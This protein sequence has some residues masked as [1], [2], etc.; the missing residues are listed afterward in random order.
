MCDYWTS[1]HSSRSFFV[2]SG[3]LTHTRQ[4]PYHGSGQAH[5]NL[6]SYKYSWVHKLRCIYL[7]LCFSVRRGVTIPPSLRNVRGLAVP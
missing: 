2:S 5:G 6:S 3:P 1:K 4:D 7:G